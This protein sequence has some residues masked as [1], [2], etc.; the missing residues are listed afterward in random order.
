MST[1]LFRTTPYFSLGLLFFS[2][3]F[4]AR[5]QFTAYTASTV[6]GQTR[7]TGDGGLASQA[8]LNRPAGLVYDSAGNLYIADQDDFRIRKMDTQG[9][10]STFAGTGCTDI[11][12]TAAPPA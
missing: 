10:I 5:A 6:A 12:A 3:N 11:Q 1:A 7:P 4:E 8:L 2:L 9:K